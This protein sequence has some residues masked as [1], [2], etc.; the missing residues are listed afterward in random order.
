[1]CEIKVSFE[2]FYKAFILQ[3]NIDIKTGDFCLI[4]L[5]VFNRLEKKKGKSTNA[6]PF[7]VLTKFFFE[8]TY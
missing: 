5:Q 1:M 2:I 8:L 4:L 7:F 6:I 3:G